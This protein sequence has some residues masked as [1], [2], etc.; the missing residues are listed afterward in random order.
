M[1]TGS[2]ISLPWYFKTSGPAVPL[3][4]QRLKASFLGS[5]GPYG[6]LPEGS[7]AQQTIAERANSE[8]AAYREAGS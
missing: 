2:L 4:N 3:K 6:R 1:A 8:Q 7:K 5:A